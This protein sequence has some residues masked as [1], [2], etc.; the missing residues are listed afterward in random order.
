MERR[1]GGGRKMTKLKGFCGCFAEYTLQYD[2]DKFIEPEFCP[3]C[4]EPTLH[5]EEEGD[6]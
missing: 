2:S 4:G 5:E 1:N 3:F 6:E